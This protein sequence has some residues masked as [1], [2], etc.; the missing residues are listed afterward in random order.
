MRKEYD[1]NSWNAGYQAMESLTFVSFHLGH[2]VMMLFLKLQIL[3]KA[4]Y[5]S[6]FVCVSQAY[7]LNFFLLQLFDYIVDNDSSSALQKLLNFR[8]QKTK[9]NGQQ[10]SEL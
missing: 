5:C 9:P 10:N 2:V 6:T 7:H 1:T 8:Y 3:R 4:G